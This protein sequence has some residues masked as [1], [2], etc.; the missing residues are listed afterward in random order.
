M[1]GILLSIIGG[2]ER[3]PPI[4]ALINFEDKGIIYM[5]NRFKD[6]ISG[7]LE[8]LGKIKDAIPFI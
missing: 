7:I 3:S 1:H 6:G 4:N 2:A 8:H 5:E